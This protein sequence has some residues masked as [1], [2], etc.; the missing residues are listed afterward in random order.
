M[1]SYGD[2]AVGPEGTILD[3]KSTNVNAGNK[4]STKKLALKDDNEENATLKQKEIVLDGSLP[5]ATKE[6]F[7]ISEELLFAST[8]PKNAPSSVHH[9][10]IEDG[11]SAD[12]GAGKEIVLDAKDVLARIP[13]AHTE[14]SPSSTT[15]HA[16]NAELA[17]SRI[18]QL[19]VSAEKYAHPPRS[20][21]SLHGKACLMEA[22]LQAG[23]QDIHLQDSDSIENGNMIRAARRTM[24]S[25]RIMP[26]RK[27]VR[28][29]R[30]S[31]ASSKSISQECNPALFA[32]KQPLTTDFDV[33]ENECDIDVGAV[34]AV[35]REL[36]SRSLLRST[37]GHG[38]IASL[39][40]MRSLDSFASSSSSCLEGIPTIFETKQP[41]LTDSLSI[42]NAF[43]N[44]LN[45][46]DDENCDED[47]LE[48]RIRAMSSASF[49][50]SVASRRSFRSRGSF[51][52]RS[53]ISLERNPSLFSRTQPF[54]SDSR[55]LVDAFE[56]ELDAIDDEDEDDEEAELKIRALWSASNHGSM[57]S[58]RSFRSRDSFASLR[59]SSL[60]RNPRIFESKQ[61]LLTD[62]RSGINSFEEELDAIGDEDYDDDDLE[63]R[64][65]S[66]SSAC[67]NGRLA[68]LAMFSKP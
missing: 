31:F 46:I 37:S 14:P 56:N 3:E 55:S 61:P 63:V 25:E 62:S 18:H 40:S 41:L 6:V 39:R 43:E 4:D 53:S 60:E 35:D 34:D 67:F 27:S 22:S 17:R 15:D 23:Q 11:S 16:K 52:S 65:R 59:N 24:S 10:T 32:K 9:L 12:G 68:S 64:M 58:L 1:D 50:G 26:A 13:V 54:V 44:E 51:A 33:Y 66:M 47:D 42:V 20:S 8:N 36:S 29:S 5:V 48:F 57:T 49:S 21:S 19:I 7:P 30:G 38:S 28:S 45:A 2:R